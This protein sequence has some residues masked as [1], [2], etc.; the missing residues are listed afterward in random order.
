MADESRFIATTSVARSD[1][2]GSIYFNVLAKGSVDYT[3]HVNVIA[4][5]KTNEVM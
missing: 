4:T 3:T 5:C 2:Y 1:L